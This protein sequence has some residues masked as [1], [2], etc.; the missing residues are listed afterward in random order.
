V[1][2][3]PMDEVLRTCIAQYEMVV[4][5]RR[6]MPSRGCDLLQPVEACFRSPRSRMARCRHESRLALLLIIPGC[7]T[8]EIFRIC[9][10]YVKYELFWL[11]PALSAAV[12]T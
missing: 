10:A 4:Q 11:T 2:G 9:Q 3:S 6:A 7:V 5:V 12:R 1:W 8:L